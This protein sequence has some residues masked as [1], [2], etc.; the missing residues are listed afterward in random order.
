MGLISSIWSGVKS[1]IAGGIKIIVAAGKAAWT[2]L[3]FAC[4]AALWIV[5]G[6]FTMAAA[7]VDYLIGTIKSFFKP[8][9]AMTL[10]K[11]QINLFAEFLE[12]QKTKGNVAEDEEEL[13]IDIKN[14][15]KEAYENNEI[16]I[17]AKG[18]DENGEEALAE[19]KFVKA[20]DYDQ[21]IKDADEDGRIY[22]KK[23]KIAG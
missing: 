13:V 11:N 16:L 10:G 22:V 17:V 2:M 9:E 7:G 12:E 5:T 23:V 1:I 20:T 18:V 19:P 6:I 8:K 3:K 21:K 14:R 4:K 15:C